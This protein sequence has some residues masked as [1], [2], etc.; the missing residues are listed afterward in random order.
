MVTP[1][2]QMRATVAPPGR[3]L[4]ARNGRYRAIVLLLARLGLRV[5]EV[6]QLR[7]Q[8]IDWLRVYCTSA[9]ANRAGNAASHCKPMPASADLYCRVSS[10]DQTCS[11]QEEDA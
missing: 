3:G 2:R 5:G 1:P 4:L 9:P 11:R 7:L 6:R 10:A 8:D